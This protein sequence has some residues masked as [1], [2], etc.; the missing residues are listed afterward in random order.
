ML[1]F[2]FAVFLAFLIF[3]I[4][5]GNTAGNIVYLTA[6]LIWCTAVYLFVFI[7]NPSIVYKSMKKRLSG[8]TSVN[9]VL[10]EK[11][12][13]AETALEKKKK[14]YSDMF[15]I[16]ET[17]DYFFFYFKRNEAYILKKSGIESGS[18]DEITDAVLKQAPAKF[19][20]GAQK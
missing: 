13:T 7:I 3:C 2:L 15:H 12:M 8:E 9:Y 17:E 1:I 20:G 19:T 10:K 16:Y 14:R 18:P 5:T 4:A 11:H 6:G